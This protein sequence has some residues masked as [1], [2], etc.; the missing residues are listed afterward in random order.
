VHI[1]TSSR[2]LAWRLVR[3]LSQSVRP[4]QGR[5]YGGGRSRAV[6][7]WPCRC[8]NRLRSGHPRPIGRPRRV[9]FGVGTYQDFTRTGSRRVYAWSPLVW[10]Q[11]YSDSPS[12]VSSARPEPDICGQSTFLCSRE[13]GPRRGPGRSPGL[14]AKQ[15]CRGRSARQASQLEA[16]WARSQRC[17]R[18]SFTSGS[19]IGAGW[20]MQARYETRSQREPREESIALMVAVRL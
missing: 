2:D 4:C 19:R 14:L 7:W 1:V 12:D 10:G 3:T 16:W 5:G 17:W 13:I 20:S 6:R 15:P 18:A 9:T 11:R 8:R